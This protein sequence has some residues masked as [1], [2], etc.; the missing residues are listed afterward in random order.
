MRLARVGQH[1]A[2]G[3]IRHFDVDFQCRHILAAIQLHLHL[4]AVD[5][6]MAGRSPPRISSRSRAARSDRPPDVRSCASRTCNRSRATGAELR[7]WNIIA[8]KFTPPSVR[9][10]ARSVPVS[11]SARPMP[12]LRPAGAVR[13]RCRPWPGR[14]RVVQRNRH[15][16]I[17]GFQHF[18]AVGD[19]A[20]QRDG[21][22]FQHVFNLQHLAACGALRVVAGQQQVLFPSARHVRR[23]RSWNPTGR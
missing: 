10:D 16:D 20:Q 19:D 2:T 5:G 6:D 18:L 23:V 14:G 11:R 21:Q 22:D 9:T 17:A 8:N 13:L 3:H 12:G 7:R 4:V 1:R 15:T